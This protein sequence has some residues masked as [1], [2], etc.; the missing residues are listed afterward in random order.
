[1][2]YSCECSR[3]RGV[4]ESQGVYSQVARHTSAQLISSRK[5]TYTP[6]V[7]AR[8]Q[9]NNNTIQSGEVPFFNKRG[10]S[11]PLWGVE[12]CSL[13]SRRAQPNPSYPALCRQDT[14]HISMEHRLRRKQLNSDT[15]A[16]KKKIFE[17]NTR[18]KEKKKLFLRKNEKRK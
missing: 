6:C 9:N 14:T 3:A 8:V 16:S 1:M 4:P 5:W 12:A 10:A 18:K 11:T 15:N 7:G 2:T 13:P 17:R